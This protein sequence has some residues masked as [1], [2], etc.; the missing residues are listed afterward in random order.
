[1]DR[2][3][4]HL[5][6]WIGRREA[7]VDEVTA[8]PV[9]ALSALL[10]RDDPEPHE[11]DP[12]PPLW[13][14]LYAMPICPLSETGEDGH[15]KRGP[16]LPPAP[17]PQR[18]WAGGRIEFFHP[19]HIGNELRR[20][21]VVTNVETKTGK[22]G[23]LVFVQ[24]SHEYSVRARIAIR[25]V[26][27]IVYRNR[28]ARGEP[29]PPPRPA[30][31]NAEW[32]A[33]FRSDPVIQFR[34]SALTFNSFRPHYDRPYATHVDHFPG[35]TVHAPL[36]ATLLMELVRRPG[37]APA[38]SL[39]FRA[40]A[41]LFD[42]APFTLNGARTDDSGIRLWAARDDGALAMDATLE[43]GEPPRD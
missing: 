25:E 23:P 3:F 1:M 9:S 24:V 29:A 14:W 36:V 27:D 20:D 34:Y 10:D 39:T 43:I 37:M 41:P 5:N 7:M 8:H 38:R 32:T 4:A 2:E 28:P 40:V 33:E 19:V 12:L 17:L 6:D 16:F 13:H 22:T 18:L 31:Q 30:P 26:H 21:S 35:L 11:G 42:I 15:P